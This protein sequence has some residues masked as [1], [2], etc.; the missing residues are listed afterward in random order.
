MKQINLKPENTSR[1]EEL[2]RERKESM[3]EVANRAVEIYW[4]ITKRKIRPEVLAAFEEFCQDH[5]ELLKRL[6]DA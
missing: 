6:A 5:G 1:L 2:A 4:A 3:D